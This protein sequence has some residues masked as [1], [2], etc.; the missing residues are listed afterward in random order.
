MSPNQIT[1]RLA[2]Y[3]FRDLI[4]RER[5]QATVDADEAL[6][7]SLNVG[8]IR[9]V[10]FTS[11]LK[12]IED[13]ILAYRTNPM[14]YRIIELNTSY[15]LGGGTTLEANPKEVQD[16]LEKWW[17]HRQN[18]LPIRQFDLMNE[19]STTGELFVTYHTN[20]ADEMTYI[21]VVPASLIDNI[22]TDANDR[23][24]EL[25]FHEASSNQVV[26]G[27]TKVGETPDSQGRWWT[28]ED[29]SHF[30]INRVTGAVRGQGD[31]VPT[32][33]W[34]SR[35][36]EWLDNRALV[37]K[38]KSA[39]V[40][41]V[42]MEGADKTAIDARKAEL[43]APSSAS[44][45]LHNEREEWNAITPNIAADDAERDGHALR[46]M[47]ATGVG[48]PLHFLS[49]GSETNVAT[50]REQSRPAL[51][52]LGRRQLH[53]G[54]IFEE[55]ANRAL[56]RS[57]QFG[58]G[59]WDVKA[60]FE[61]LS[62]R[63]TVESANATRVGALGLEIAVERGWI[64]HDEARELFNRFAEYTGE[65]ENEQTERAAPATR[66]DDKADPRNTASRSNG[67]GRHLPSE[68]GSL[69]D[70]TRL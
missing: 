14:A 52:Q 50:A 32:L 63:D 19:L 24:R 20:P 25:R 6:Y 17:T 49:E 66:S 38:F 39:F 62:R 7:R 37:N 15:V 23:E 68:D 12:N 57:D 9:D 4:S 44:V 36:K 65:A 67:G 30:T 2:R 21:R 3:L 29:M 28:A 34:L 60:V 8:G 48:L 35:Y 40:W 69:S 26:D 41:D 31:L 33:P 54:E 5:E 11:H 45:L 1:D 42:K 61:D 59:P 16:W 10:P 53:V 43:T 13:S 47:I 51:R 27:I 58:A 56:T 18:R 64:T 55:I 22:E 70:A 46:L